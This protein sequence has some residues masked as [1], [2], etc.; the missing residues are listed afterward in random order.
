MGGTEDWGDIPLFSPR[1]ALPFKG[2]ERDEPWTAP[3]G[4]AARACMAIPSLTATGAENRMTRA[5]Y[6]ATIFVRLHQAVRV[7]FGKAASAT[8]GQDQIIAPKT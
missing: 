3:V 4:P 7:P 6:E 1:M 8:G 5:E 2:D